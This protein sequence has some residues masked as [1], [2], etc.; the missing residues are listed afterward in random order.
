MNSVLKSFFREHGSVKGEPAD[1]SLKQL[2]ES[3]EKDMA[4][5]MSQQ[6]SFSHEETRLE[7]Q[8]CPPRPYSATENF[9]STVHDIC[10][11][12][13]MIQLLSPN[14]F[15]SGCD[16]HK[17]ANKWRCSLQLSCVLASCCPREL[18]EY[19]LKSQDAAHN[20]TVETCKK[21][22]YFRHNIMAAI[23]IFFLPQP[24]ETLLFILCRWPFPEQPW[25]Q[26]FSTVSLVE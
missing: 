19:G 8:D 6:R 7:A 18:A 1:D 22:R 9:C 23:L 3:M 2:Y 26:P 24:A 25:F 10:G 15:Y 21:N 17:K 5:L 4:D 20:S 13:N 11:F 16:C 14:S 12:E